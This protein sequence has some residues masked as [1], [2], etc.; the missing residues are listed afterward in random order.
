MLLEQQ[1]P[2]VRSQY[3]PPIIKQLR[4]GR[5]RS[6]HKVFKCLASSWTCT[7]RSSRHVH[8]ANPRGSWTLA[9]LR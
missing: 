1:G 7:R 2:L 9:P 8:A 3:D 4:S 6:I 5:S